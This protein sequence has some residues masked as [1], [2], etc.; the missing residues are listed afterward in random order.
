[1]DIENIYNDLVEQDRVFQRLVF[2]SRTILKDFKKNGTISEVTIC[3]LET[4]IKEADE[5][6]IHGLASGKKKPGT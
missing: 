2:L 5:I 3:E 1:M 4:V 6:G